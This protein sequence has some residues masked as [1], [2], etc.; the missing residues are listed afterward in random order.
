MPGCG[1]TLFLHNLACSRRAIESAIVGLARVVDHHKDLDSHTLGAT[2]LCM[3]GG[4]AYR[5]TAIEPRYRFAATLFPLFINMVDPSGIPQWMRSGPWMALQTGEANT[6]QFIAEMGPD[7][8]DVPRVPFFMVHG[9]HDNWM[10]W[11]AA[12]ALLQRVEHPQRR[13]LTLENPPV[14][15]GGNA[16]THAMPVGDLMHWVVPIVADW[17]ADRAAEL[18]SAGTTTKAASP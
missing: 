1:A 11:D 5:A 16:T 6:D 12:N 4:Y 9:R 3:G 7:P 17:L 10:T 8:E 2:G 18:H 14:L 15:T 13:L